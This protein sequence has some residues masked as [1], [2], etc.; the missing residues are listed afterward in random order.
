MNPISTSA[1][2]RVGSPRKKLDFSLRSRPTAIYSRSPAARPCDRRGP[3][4]LSGAY[5][6]SME[7]TPRRAAPANETSEVPDSPSSSAGPE[8]I[9]NV[10][11]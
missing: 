11:V 8:S 10:P 6:R 5:S 4:W 7:Y 2:R 3:S 1:D 9:T